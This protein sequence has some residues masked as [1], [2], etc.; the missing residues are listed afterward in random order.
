M[1]DASSD[2]LRPTPF[3]VLGAGAVTRARHL[4]ALQA[5]GGRAVS[6]F[7]PD[8]QAASSAGAAFGIPTVAASA[9]AAVLHPDAEAVLV[10]SPN[11]FHR[12]QTELALAADRHVL[13]EK[14][15]ALRLADAQAMASAAK[16]AGKV[17]QVGFH[18]RFGSEHLCVRKL[19]RGGVL[20]EIRGFH[21]AISEPFDII[22]GGVRNYRFDA[23]QGGGFT[24]ID[25]GQ[26]R[27]DQMRDLL[28]DFATVSCEMGSVLGSHDLDDNVV[29]SVRMESGALGSLNWHR[30]SRA[31][32]SPL[33][34]YGTKAVVGCSTF[35]AAPFQS[36]PVAVYLEDDPPAVLPPD[37]LAWT[38]PGR[39]WGDLEP[40]WINIWPPR[41]QTFEAQFRSFFAAV[42]GD[43]PP[44]ADGRDGY[45]ALGG[46]PSRLPVLRRAAHGRIAAGR[47]GTP[48]PA[49][50]A[51][52][53]RGPR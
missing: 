24:L 10:A 38:R 13:C 17:L 4:P 8:A 12:E 26:H 19:I 18:H 7:D 11:A 1:P 32:T 5:V 46:R 34:L 52:G 27:I 22:P 44:R 6:I 36:A 15:A 20:G 47:G 43:A 28:G 35:I 21:A 29:L 37:I 41:T 39:W 14:P 49:N 53:R 25:V 48:C 3:A 51:A 2:R 31:F 30:F 50:L 9:E 33:M 40:G 16:Q 42:R 45:K 23:Q